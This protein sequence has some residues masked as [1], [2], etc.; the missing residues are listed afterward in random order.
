MAATA[1]RPLP[2]IPIGEYLGSVYRPDVD[3][4]DGELE[5]RNVGEFDHA[6]VQLALVRALDPL[7]SQGYRCIAEARVQVSETR[8]RVPDVC[9]LPL[10]WKRA[11]IIHT[12]P[13]LCIEV[14]SPRDTVMGMRVRSEDYLRMGVPVVWLFD[15]RERKAYVLNR[16]G[17]REVSSGALTIS[18][19]PVSVQVQ[20][21]FSVLDEE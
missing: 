6:D 21:I 20:E 5:E 17:M 19:A 10:G 8:F 13:L 9:L 1:A 11:Q 3:Y 2:H 7:R 4:V 16:D 14:L 18:D 12:P 15:P